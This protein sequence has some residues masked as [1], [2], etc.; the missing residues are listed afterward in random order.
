[1]PDH[2]IIASTTSALPIKDIASVSKRPERIIGMHYFSPVDKMQ[3]LEIVVSDQTSKETLAVAAKLGL[4]QKKII[5]VVKDGP[6]FF[7]VRCLG[8]MLSEVV[9]LLQEGVSPVELDNLTKVCSTNIWIYFLGIWFSGGGG[10][11]S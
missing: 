1:M 3:L 11:V 8:P 10:N 4:A 2:C 7:T 9:R 6:G 5:V